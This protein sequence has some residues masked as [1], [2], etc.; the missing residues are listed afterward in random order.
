[1]TS[2]STNTVLDCDRG[3]LQQV[4]DSVFP[5]CLTAF[6]H[7]I[8]ATN[9]TYRAT[10]GDPGNGGFCYDSRPGPSCHTG[11]CPLLKI[12]QGADEFS[13]EASKVD[14]SRIRT[15][16]VTARPLRNAEGTPIGIVESFQDITRRKEMEKEQERLILKLETALAEVR[17]L[18]GLLPICSACKKIRDDDGRWSEVEA[19]V[20]TRSEARFTHGMCPDCL[21]QYYP[22]YATED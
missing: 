21:K 8:L 1:M 4:L 2:R 5:I 20:S 18:R 7:R 15:F 13:C 14:E 16:I 17:V 9:L 10:F 22:E 12:E 11:N 6:D 3:Q 19:Y